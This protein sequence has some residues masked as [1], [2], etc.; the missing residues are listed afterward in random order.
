MQTPKSGFGRVWWMNGMVSRWTKATDIQLGL[1][2]G[3]PQTVLLLARDDDPSTAALM[4]PL[5]SVLRVEYAT[6]EER[7]AI[8]KAD[9]DKRGAR[10]RNLEDKP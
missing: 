10:T 9:A 6:E 7:K 4:V 8:E 1:Q 3:D 5:L 2:E